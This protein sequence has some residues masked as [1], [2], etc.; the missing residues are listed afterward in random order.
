MSTH[1]TPTPEDETPDRRFD[2]PW[3]R[4]LVAAVVGWTV[5]YA[6]DWLLFEAG[7]PAGALV[8]FAHAYLLAPLATAT[9]LLDALSLS[10]RGIADFGLFKWLYALVALVAPPVAVVYYAH[11]EWLKPEHTD[12][13]GDPSR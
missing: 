4:V 8:G 11:R 13:L 7:T 2:G 12:L 9:V 3:L 6:L 10:E 1:A 5:L